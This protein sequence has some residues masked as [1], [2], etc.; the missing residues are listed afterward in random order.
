MNLTCPSCAT[1]FVVETEQLG[2]G[3]RQVRCGSCGH[4]W[5]QDAD[6]GATESGAGESAPAPPEA[7]P[8]VPPESSPESSPESAP[9]AAAPPEKR[10]KR[11]RRRG[12]K[13]PR[14]KEVRSGR[15]SL[16]LGW[17]LF[18]AVIGG[19][20]AGLYFGRAQVLALVP[21]AEPL[22]QMAGL[23]PPPAGVPL[24]LRDVKTVRRVVEGEPVVV[25]EGLVSNATDEPQAVPLLRVSL[26]DAKGNEVES[27]TFAA[28]VTTLQPG[29]TADFETIAKNPPKEGRV[30]IDFVVAP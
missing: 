4:S 22:Y 26:I 21:A 29:G 23:M 24:E 13:P 6:S 19:L 28:S 10:E 12:P 16:I 2:P 30:L 7:A 14:Q 17:I 18:L 1:T 15:A 8:E 11:P 25:V 20:A 27:W 3:G 9:L 5:H